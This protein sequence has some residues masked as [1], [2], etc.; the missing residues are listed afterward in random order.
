MSVAK[1]ALT[2]PSSTRTP[3]DSS[4]AGRWNL[5]WNKTRT[6][7]LNPA[8]HPATPWSH[9]RIRVAFA[10]PAD[11]TRSLLRRGAG[12]PRFAAPAHRRDRGGRERAGAGSRAAR[13]ALGHEAADRALGGGLLRGVLHEVR[14]AEPGDMAAA[15]GFALALAARLCLTGSAPALPKAW[16]WIRQDLAGRETGEPYGPGLAAFGLDPARLVIVATA[17]AREALRAAEEGL[18][19]AALGCVLLEPWGDTRALDLTA[20]RRLGLAAENSGVTLLMLRSGTHEDGR[21]HGPGGAMTRWSIAA[22]PSIGLPAAG[23]MPGVGRPAFGAGLLRN[24]QAGRLGDGGHWTMEW[25]CDERLLT[26]PLGFPATPARA[27]ALPPA[28]GPAAPAQPFAGPF[29]KS[30]AD[31][32]RAS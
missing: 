7:S 19:C 30:F 27:R 15:A 22:A 16:L 20:M 28:D 24:R 10:R 6:H 31:T 29:A 11:R 2:K 23:G 12:E 17:D 18:G 14:P 3:V 5:I 32:R 4:A 8:S 26:P 21:E 1:T 9:A 13:L 25:N